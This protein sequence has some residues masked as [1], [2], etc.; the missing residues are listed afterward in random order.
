[1]DRIGVKRWLSLVLL[2]ALAPAL[3]AQFPSQGANAPPLAQPW[4]TNAAPLAPELSDQYE[5]WTLARLEAV[6]E[7]FNPILPR[8]RAQVES[9]RGSALQAGIWP[10][11]RF[12]TNNPQVLIGRA[13][14]L[15]AGFRQEVPVMGKKRLDQAAATEVARQSEWSYHADR[16]ALLAAIRQ[17][18]FMVLIDQRRIEV[19]SE[20]AQLTRETHQ[21]GEKR[22]K[23]G[24]ASRADVLVL[25]IDMQRV[26]ASLRSARAILDG[27]R[28]QLGAIVGVPGIVT[29]DVSGRVT[30]PYPQFNEEG[31][32]HYVTTQHTQIITA[33]S[34]IE[35]SKYLL[36]RAEVEPYPN[37]YFGPAYQF[38]LVPGSD[39]FWFNIDFPITF[40][41]RNQGNIRAARA[42]LTA[43]QNNINTIRN[44]LLNQAANLLSQYLAALAVAR[45]FEADILPNTRE[46]VR[47]A[48]EGYAKGLT[49][50]ATF[51]AV[52]RTLI[53]A[54]SDYVDA[55][56]NL[57]SNAV[58]LAG[59][60][61]LER[62]P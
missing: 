41:D 5:P 44:S 43:A 60:V 6:A 20:M 19:L 16:Y 45:Q 46:S 38:G 50:F 14:A 1:M 42:N 12:D 59:L 29:R 47:L 9:A 34:V 7:Q 15:N 61:Q 28:K 25:Q 54:N 33:L 18:F 53:Q 26:D 36:R 32:K 10:N 55:L 62:F 35:Q 40:W 30:S 13:T 58:Q 57:W 56:N 27:D 31:I 37:P 4:G 23:A 48:R 21:T 11:P 24:E 2:G 49:D 17:Q 39:N 8:D 51:L 22:L 52:Q 3:P